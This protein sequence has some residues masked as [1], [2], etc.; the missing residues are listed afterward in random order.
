MVVNTPLFTSGLN[1]AR[2]HAAQE[3]DRRAELVIE[4]TRRDVLQ[5]VSQAWDQLSSTRIAITLQQQELDQ[6][7]VAVAGNRLEEQV[8][9]RSV[10]D[11]LNSELELV[12]VRTELIQSRHDEYVARAQLLS[13]MGLLEA[14][15]LVPGID[16]YDPRSTTW[17]LPAA[18]AA[19]FAAGASAIDGLGAARTAE[20]LMSAP[21]AGSAR[22]TTPPI[23]PPP[24]PSP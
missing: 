17:S 19:P 8:G 18:I 14:R 2:I 15:L 9:L 13:A 21:G 5:H 6:E 24:P 22:P 7:N 23:L 4:A 16:A 12:N 10:I 1:S 20:P 3:D 11:L